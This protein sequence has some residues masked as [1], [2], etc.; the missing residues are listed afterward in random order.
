LALN[1]A[2]RPSLT[3]AADA[4]INPKRSPWCWPAA[5]IGVTDEIGKKIVERP[6]TVADF[7]ATIHCALGIDPSKNLYAGDRPVPITDHSKPVT[8]LFV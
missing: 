4:A 7:H 5:A 8:E 6:L 1:S 3:A 2:A